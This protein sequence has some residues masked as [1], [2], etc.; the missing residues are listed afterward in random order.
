MSVQAEYMQRMQ[1]DL[2]PTN[3]PPKEHPE[4]VTAVFEERPFDPDG[5]G[6]CLT[7][8]AIIPAAM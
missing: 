7:P 5:S 2:P 1:R 6:W 8:L 4:L 3:L